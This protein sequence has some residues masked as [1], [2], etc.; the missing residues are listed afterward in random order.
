MIRQH[1]AF[2]ETHRRNG[3][4]AKIRQG[5]TR[6][7]A[8]G[9]GESAQGDGNRPAADPQARGEPQTPQLPHREQAEGPARRE[10]EV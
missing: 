5:R 3:G 9:G 8:A 2:Q 4:K 6:A 10:G 1:F 7:D